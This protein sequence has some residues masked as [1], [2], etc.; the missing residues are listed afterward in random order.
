[1]TSAR[2]KVWLLFFP[3]TMRVI[4]ILF[5]LVGFQSFSQAQASDYPTLERVL[6]VEQCIDEQ[7]QRPRQELLFKCVCVFDQLAANIAFDDFV[8]LQTAAN[9]TTIKG[10][11]GRIM[12]S[13]G[14]RAQADDFRHRLG[15]ARAACLLSDP[16]ALSK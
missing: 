11:R 15:E 9:A 4:L 14:I 1:M 2:G 5:T 7:P 6:F 3:M 13:P 12:R 10:E 8:T 16:I